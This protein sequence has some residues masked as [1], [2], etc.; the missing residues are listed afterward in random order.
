MISIAGC[1]V[2]PWTFRSLRLNRTL[3]ASSRLLLTMI[4][5]TDRVVITGGGIAG[6]ASALALTKV[7]F[8]ALKGEIFRSSA[9][10]L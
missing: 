5:A 6:L 10:F 2:L 8:P 3:K 7:P 1:G 4:E 9:T